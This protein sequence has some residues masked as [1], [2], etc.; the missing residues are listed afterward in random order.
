MV[1]TKILMVAR[2]AKPP[3]TYIR[4][5]SKSVSTATSLMGLGLFAAFSLMN[6]KLIGRSVV[7][8]VR[9]WIRSSPPMERPKRH[10]NKAQAEAHTVKAHVVAYQDKNPTEILALQLLE[11]FV[12][13]DE[14]DEYQGCD[15]SGP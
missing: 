10:Q 4:A 3:R 5:L 6:L 7:Q 2:A 13:E 14:Q 1:F 12:S 11:P 15:N 8:G 9:Q